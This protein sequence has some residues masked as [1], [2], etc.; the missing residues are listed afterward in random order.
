MLGAECLQFGIDCFLPCSG[1]HIAERMGWVEQLLD[2]LGAS[3][4]VKERIWSGTAAAWLGLG[5][6]RSPLAP[7]DDPS[8]GLPMRLRD[9][10]C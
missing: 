9:V 8:D 5:A 3:P 6:E 4:A 1:A 10:C 7:E 2:E